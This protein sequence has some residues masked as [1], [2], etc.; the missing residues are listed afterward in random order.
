MNTWAFQWTH[1]WTPKIQDGGDLPS[2]K[3]TSRH[4]SAEIWRTFDRIQCHPTATCHI[5]GWKNSIRH[6]IE[7]RSSPYFIFVF[8]MRFG[9]RRAAAFV[10]SSIHLLLVTSARDLQLNS[11]VFSSAYTSSIAVIN[12]IHWRVTFRRHGLRDKQTPILT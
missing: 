7:N 5:A 12:K 6:I 4:F 11:A 8:L 3:S 10:S 2:W 1:C 9:L